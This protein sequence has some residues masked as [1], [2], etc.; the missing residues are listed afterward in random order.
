LSDIRSISILIPNHNKCYDTGGAS[1][2][3]HSKK[4]IKNKSEFIS[5][6]VKKA[7][8]EV[9][10]REFEEK[11]YGKDMP[12]AY[13]DTNVLAWFKKNKPYVSQKVH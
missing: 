8:N 2:T 10:L 4:K 11:S 9:L 13:F 7:I 1:F 6:A 3:F 5:Y 12:T